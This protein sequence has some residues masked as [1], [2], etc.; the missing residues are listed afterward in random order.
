M[1]QAGL[2]NFMPIHN[3]QQEVKCL[4]TQKEQENSG[5]YSQS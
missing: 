5:L 2:Q 1:M 4:L 3:S